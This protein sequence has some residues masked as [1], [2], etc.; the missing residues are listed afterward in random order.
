MRSKARLA[1]RLSVL[2]FVF[3]FTHS[4][5]AQVNPTYERGLKAYGSYEGAKID[6]ISLV[7]GTLNLK[8]PLYSL[9]QRGGLE[10]TVF[11]QYWT[12]T[13]YREIDT[14]FKPYLYIWSY[15]TPPAVDARDSTYMYVGATTVGYGYVYSATTADGSTHQMADTGSGWESIDA[16]GFKYDPATKIVTDRNGTRYYQ[17]GY[18]GDKYVKDRNGNYLSTASYS[19]PWVD[20]LGRS[21]PRPPGTATT[22][23]SGCRGPYPISSAKLWTVPGPNGGTLSFKFCYVTLSTKSDFWPLGENSTHY[24][25]EITNGSWLQSVVLPDNTGVPSASSQ[26]WIFQYDAVQDPQLARGHLGDLVQ[27]TLPTGGYIQYGW[28]SR[29]P[30]KGADTKMRGVGL[31]TFDANDGTGPHTSTIGVMSTVNLQ[32]TSTDAEGNQT[33]HTFAALGGDPTS[34]AYYEAQTQYYEGPTSNN[35]LLKTVTT[36]YAADPYIAPDGTRLAMNVVP[37]RVTT[38][39]PNGQVSKVEKTYDYGFT[40][41]GSRGTFGLVLSQ[42]DYDWGTGAAG[43]KLRQ[44]DHTYLALS[45]SNYKT[46]NLLDLVTQT[47]VKNGTGTQVAQTNF[48]YDEAGR[49]ISSGISTHRDTAVT[50]RGNQTSVSRWRNLPTVAWLTTQKYYYDTGML[51]KTID[52]GTHATTF[53]YSSTFAGAYLTQVTNAKN[54]ISTKNYDFNT[55]LLTSE[56]DPNNQSTTYTYYADARPHEVIS[57]DGGR[58]TYTYLDGPSVYGVTATTKI[59]DTP[60]VLQRVD[61]A[62]LDGLARVKQTERSS[63]GGNIFTDVTYD[64][65]GRKATVSNPY[66]SVGDPTYGITSYQYDAL[67]RVVLEIPP[68]GSSSSNNVSTNYQG[69]CATV[70][71]QAGKQRKSC[72][73]GLGR[74]VQVFESPNSL[75]YETDY[76]YDALGD[77]TRIDQ[78]GN[79]P[80]D[81]SKWRTRTGSYDSLGRLLSA[82]NPE[83]G[84]TSWTYDNDSNVLTK[85]DARPVTVTYSWDELHRNTGRTYSNGDTAVGYGYDQSSAYGLNI[86]YGIG[87]QTSMSDASGTSAWSF[88]QTGRAKVRQRTINIS[89]L[90]P[91]PVTKTTTLAF[92]LDGSVASITYPS[93]RIVDY[94]YDTSSNAI[95]AINHATG[96]KYVSSATYAP[97]DALAQMYLGATAQSSGIAVTE[98]YNNRLQPYAI[99]AIS[100]TMTLLN[101]CYNFNQALSSPTC[102]QIQNAGTFINNGTLGRIINVLDGNRTQ[103]FTYDGINRL[104]AAWT[105]GPN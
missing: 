62:Y 98:N 73:D 25:A 4:I 60:Q 33:V 63:P 26:A 67:G 54:Q 93:G 10:Y 18:N 38:T 44:T 74:L 17:G 78:K 101:R 82:C 57:P 30:C 94:E 81:S 13:F 64:A 39:L 15:G 16:T 55:G 46:A 51:Q 68:D 3:V 96:Y 59:H 102:T 70:T 53:A 47:T 75:N 42:S 40:A 100:P 50:Y 5:R 99:S 66:R 41:G 89:G 23:Y 9:P 29:G 103:N 31:R 48:S 36:D 1:T 12:P 61:S 90:T 24:E 104:T 95:S 32:G 105:D 21:I 34:C 87:H 19:S 79:A 11:L 83:S 71:D 84:T 8:I 14:E 28:G 52:P 69:N 7:N 43:A 6:Q 80:T 86:A 58:T 56:T 49:L 85:T 76:Q 45:N 20:S 27:V 97:Q 88:D 65:V 37:T 91:S 72:T 35:V 77:L 2:L 22:D 92:N